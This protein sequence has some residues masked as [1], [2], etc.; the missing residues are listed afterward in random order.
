MA[1]NRP[2]IASMSLGRPWIHDLP[3]KLMTAAAHGF[4]GIE[5]FFDDLDCYA[6]RTFNGD[7]HEAARA[8]RRMCERLGMAIICLQPFSM[9]EG[10]LDRAESD[11]LVCEKLP[12]WF[13]LARA[14]GTD[15]IQVPSNFLGPD[16]KTGAPRTTGDRAVIVRDLQRLADLGAG[17][18]FR[19][20]Y[21]AL[22]WG[23]HVDTWEASWEIVR[24][25]NRHNF[26]LCLDSFNIAGRVYADPACPTGRTP[27]AAADLAA[28]LDRLRK[29]KIDPAKIFYVQLV[30]GERLKAPLD[31]NHPFHVPNQP[32]RM[33]WSRNARLFP[34]EE[35]RGGYLPIVDVARVFFEDLGFKGWVSL[36][37]F[38]RTLA[39]PDPFTPVDHARRGIESYY[40]AARIF[41]FEGQEQKSLSYAPIPEPSSPVQHRL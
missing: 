6:Q 14:L 39:D 22:C 34:F 32:V 31:E 7:H 23:D 16:P 3:G 36:E 37:L 24:D 25:V 1:Y 5:L 2:G 12:K 9:Y 10:L 20:V 29:S 41:N 21:E 40:K 26:G 38:S 13:T 11:R 35:S 18:G 17:A 4:E 8:V 33:N 28:S 15:M 27:N 19:F 30:D